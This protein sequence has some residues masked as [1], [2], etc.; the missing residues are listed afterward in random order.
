MRGASRWL[1]ACGASTQSPVKAT[2]SVTSFDLRTLHLPA[3]WPPRCTAITAPLRVEPPQLRTSTDAERDRIA[4]DE[5]H[6]LA[7]YVLKRR[8]A[9]P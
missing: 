5:N 6:R 9:T 4:H 7:T 3:A 1:D 8:E 2:T